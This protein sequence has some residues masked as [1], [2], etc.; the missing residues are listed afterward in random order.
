MMDSRRVAHPA[1]PG[2]AHANALPTTPH[3]AA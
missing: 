1:P 3:V 2:L